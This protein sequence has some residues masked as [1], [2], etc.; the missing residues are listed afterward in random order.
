MT[1]SSLEIEKVATDLSKVLRSQLV[2]R[3]GILPGYPS[4]SENFH[5]EIFFA[6]AG[7]SSDRGSMLH[8]KATSYVSDLFNP[9]SLQSKFYRDCVIK[10]ELLP[11]ITQ[12]NVGE[13]GNWRELW[14][15]SKPFLGIVS[16]GSKIAREMLPHS[17][18]FSFYHGAL[19]TKIYDRKTEIKQFSQNEDSGVE[20]LFQYHAFEHLHKRFN[21]FVAEIRYVDSAR[22]LGTTGSYDRP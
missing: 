8:I 5:A 3:Y 21:A 7:F 10:D 14:L 18:F 19:A 9:P 4:G 2:I 17:P 16:F 13:N 11:I 1:D 22:A 12:W 15:D 6:D 20:F